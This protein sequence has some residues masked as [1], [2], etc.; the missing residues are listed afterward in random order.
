MHIFLRFSVI[1][2]FFLNFSYLYVDEFNIAHQMIIYWLE[3]F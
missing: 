1:F 3:L 2:T